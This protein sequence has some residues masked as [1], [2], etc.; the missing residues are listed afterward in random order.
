V[1]FLYHMYKYSG[2]LVV[3]KTLITAGVMLLATGRD[4]IHKQVNP[5]ISSSLKSYSCV[6]TSGRP[7]V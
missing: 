4:A 1:D 5:R 7:G 3:V 2:I 6:P